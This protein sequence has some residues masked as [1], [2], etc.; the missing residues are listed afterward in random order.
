LESAIDATLS[1][2]NYT[3]IVTGNAGTSPTGIAVVE[4]YDLNPAA[5]SKLANLSTRA[6]VQTGGNV[7]IAG[8]ILGNNQGEDRI[9]VRHSARA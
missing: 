3:A 2:G 5:A 4:A 8:F 1:P 7:V 9:V 6:F